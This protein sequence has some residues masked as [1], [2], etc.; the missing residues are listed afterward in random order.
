MMFS[1]RGFFVGCVGTS[2]SCWI[3]E[4]R[5][6]DMVNMLDRRGSERGQLPRET[7]G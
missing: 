5:R 6:D 1:G 2:V 7:E 4:A 3:M